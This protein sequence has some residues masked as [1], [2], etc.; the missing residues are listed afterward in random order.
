MAG[1]LSLIAEIT[2]RCPLHCVY[3]S[4][5]LVMAGSSAELT[6]EAWIDVFQQAAKMGVLQLDLTG[7]EPLARTDLIDLV[8]SARDAGL[9]VNLITSGIGLSPTKLDQLVNARLDHIQ[10]SLQD[11]EAQGAD[12]I[13][14]TK[15]HAK[16]L[17]IAAEIRK[18]RLAFTLNIVVHRQN[19]VRL[20]Q[21][22]ALAEEL[23]AH[24]LEIAH[25]QYYGW[26]FA[27]REALLPTRVQLDESLRVIQEAQAR[28][29]GRLRI[30]YVVPD[31]YAR[32]PKA[33]MGGWGRKTMLITP[34]GDVLPCHAATV[35]PGMRFENVRENKLQWIWEEADS[36]QRFR[37]IS[38]MPEPCQ[39]CD[40]RDRD[41]GGCRCQAF[42]LAGDAAVTDPV[43]SLAPMHNRVE[44]VL[45]KVN[46]TRTSPPHAELPTTSMVWQ[47]RQ[48]PR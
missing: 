22:I 2:H 26:A 25:V 15:T 40:R 32:F 18:H 30:D 16:K 27:N 10:L 44:E 9:Y 47:Y 23:G 42:L 3:C 12:E 13:A 19:L 24:K 43:C 5:P 4:N 48:N 20:P 21:M 28:L 34:A 39:S 46:T 31:Y 11:S 29:E 37:G 38:W 14:G 17:E 7:G 8:N 1:P 35:I 33:C 6:T 36:F 41:F 45:Q